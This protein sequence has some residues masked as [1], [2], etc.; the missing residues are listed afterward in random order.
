M[1]AST[2]RRTTSDTSASWSAVGCATAAPTATIKTSA[3]V[4]RAAGAPTSLTPHVI[5]GACGKNGSVQLDPEGLALMGVDSQ[6]PHQPTARSL[7]FTGA[8]VKVAWIADG[9]DPNN[10]NFIRPDGTSVFDKATGGDYEDFS[11]DGPGQVTDS[12]SS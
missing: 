5:P 1:S 4:T 8:G 2:S 9:L 6:N 11:G 3:K 12:N 7:G 10:V